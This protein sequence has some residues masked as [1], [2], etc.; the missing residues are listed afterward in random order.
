MAG[1]Q[2]RTHT[3]SGG[4]LL[5][6]HPS[7]LDNV[8]GWGASAARPF[9]LVNKSLQAR[10]RSTGS[11]SRA[12]LGDLLPSDFFLVIEREGHEH[13]AG[14]ECLCDA[15]GPTR[16]RKGMNQSCKRPSMSG[17]SQS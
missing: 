17:Q 8:G 1:Q 2:S 5:H 3:C 16:R 12:F 15:G 6:T 9:S 11:F 4:P 13:G 7:R 10:I 14:T